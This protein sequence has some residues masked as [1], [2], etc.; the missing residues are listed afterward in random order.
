MDDDRRPTTDDRRPTT[1]DRRPTTDDR[2]PTTFGSDTRGCVRDGLGGTMGTAQRARVEKSMNEDI[3][4][5]SLALVLCA[6]VAFMAGVLRERMRNAEEAQKD[7][8][9]VKDELA[10][11]RIVK[12]P[13]PMTKNKGQP[14]WLKSRVSGWNACIEETKRLN[15]GN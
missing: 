9:W 4:L 2:R 1:D 13:A 14:G 12:Y 5:W 7:A 11:A 8:V 6:G 10:K 15:K 3:A